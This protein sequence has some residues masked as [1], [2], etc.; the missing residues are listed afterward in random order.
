MGLLDWLFGEK[1]A[2]GPS[3]HD[4]AGP[5]SF[6]VRG[7]GDALAQHFMKNGRKVAVFGHDEDRLTD[8]IAA[9][10][11]ACLVIEIESAGTNGFLV[12]RTVKKDGRLS[13]I[14]LAL[15]SAEVGQETFEQHKKLRTR[16][17]AYITSAEPQEIHA[18]VQSLV[19]T[20]SV[21]QPRPA[22]P[23]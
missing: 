5:I 4:P 16:A 3:A 9:S 15:F 2:A 12:A 21:G 8:R 17:G 7:T 11:P 14:P 10:A 19:L 13:S 1:G 18:A 6:V 22:A 20:S 23:G